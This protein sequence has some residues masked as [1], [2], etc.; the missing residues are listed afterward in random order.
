MPDSASAADTLAWAY[1]EHGLYDV[2][3]DLLQEALQKAPDNATYHYHIG[4]VYLKQNNTPA[5]RKQLQR[6]LQ[7]NPNFPQAD[8]ILGTLSQ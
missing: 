2:A 3:A 1:Y 7:L 5:A 4:M 8:K 6:T